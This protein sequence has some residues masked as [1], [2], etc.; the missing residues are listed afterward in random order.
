M[1]AKLGEENKFYYDENLKTWVEK[2][3]KAPAEVAPLAPP[4][5]TTSF[6]TGL[7]DYGLNNAGIK[8]ESNMAMNGLPE[9]KPATSSNSLL[10]PGMV[11]GM[12]PMPPTHNQFSARGRMG[13]RSR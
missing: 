13:V 5:T 8:T 2:G 6:Q 7:P 12:P 11:G 1:K 10:E 4:P 3:A 9:S